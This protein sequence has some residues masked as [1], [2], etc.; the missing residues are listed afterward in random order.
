MRLYGPGVRVRRWWPAARVLG[1]IVGG[2]FAA[3]SGG[4]D[5]DSADADPGDG[6][7]GPSPELAIACADSAEEAYET[8]S[9]LPPFSPNNLGRVLRCSPAGEASRSEVASKTAS[10]PGLEVESGYRA[11]R[12]AYITERDPGEHGVASA[13]ALV[14][15]RPRPGPTPVVVVNHGTAGLADVCAPS[16]QPSLPTPELVLPWV[17]AGFFV[18]APDYAGLG[19]Q[20]VQGYGNRIDTSNSVLDAAEALVSALSPGS[21][22]RRLVVVGHSQGGGASLQAQAR[23]RT[24]S[25]QFEWVAAISVAGPDAK[26]NAAELMRFPSTPIA[27]EWGA[28]RALFAMGLYADYANLH[29]EAAAPEAFSPSIRDH[30]A[31]G[32]KTRCIESLTLFLAT[33][34]PGYDPPLSL[35]QLVDPIFRQEV[36]DCTSESSCTA[37][38]SAYVQRWKVNSSLSADPLGGPMLLLAGGL[39]A[40]APPGVMGCTRAQIEGEG[41]AVDACYFPSENHE[42]IVGASAVHAVEW[43]TEVESGRP[44]PECPETAA[45]PAC[46]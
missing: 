36:V 6:A 8:I 19:T 4:D 2:G 16:A 25:P 12:M 21:L 38:A 30:L 23:A 29:G 10:I 1:L 33:A 7:A 28:T 17:A 11:Y 40:L 13:L 24:R 35:G 32:I 45:F 3:C 27:G 34:A 18:I 37:R 5:A 22:A 15:D 41:A 20:G 14:P 39:D 31:E 44:A 46:Q 26:W 43:A 42:S 9:E